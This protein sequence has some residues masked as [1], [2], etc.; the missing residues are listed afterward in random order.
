MRLQLLMEEALKQHRGDL[1]GL[2]PPEAF[3]R[4]LFLKIQDSLR[5]G[6]LTQNVRDEMSESRIGDAWLKKDGN[7]KEIFDAFL[8]S[9]TFENGPKIAPPGRVK[10]DATRLK[11]GLE[12]LIDSH[13]IQTREYMIGV[14]A[15]TRHFFGKALGAVMISTWV[16]DHYVSVPLEI[17]PEG[18]KDLGK[19]S[20]GLEKKIRRSLLQTNLYLPLTEAGVCATGLALGGVGLGVENRGL[21][22]GGS[23]VTGLGCGAL[24]THYIIPT[25]NHYLSDTLGGVIGA[26]AGF[27]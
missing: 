9:F 18:R 4:S 22:V 3:Q 2:T 21:T 19:F 24:I 23:T 6:E 10:V 13:S 26:A 5:S 12:H 16:N 20:L 27:A 8:P 25:R 11:G 14:L 17:S 1:L 15:L 7:L